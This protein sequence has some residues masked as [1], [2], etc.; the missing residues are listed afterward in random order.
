MSDSSGTSGVL[1]DVSEASGASAEVPCCAEQP[2]QTPWTMWFDRVSAGAAYSQ[3][4]HRLG[5][6]TTVQGFWRTYCN[7]A[8]PGQLQ[9]GDNYHMF[10]GALQPAMETIPGGGCWLYRLQPGAGQQLG[11]TEVNRLWES[12]LLTLVG[13]SL[14]EACVVGAGVSVRHNIVVLTTWCCADDDQASIQRVGQRLQAVFGAE[15]KLQ[16][17]A[18]QAKPSTSSG[19]SGGG[20]SSSGSSTTSRPAHATPQHIAASPAAS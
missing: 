9:P 14:G 10:R 13:E 15:A 6:I 11:D 12:L 5:T 17:R 16:W 3:S 20:G 8:R 18:M 19:G 2:L 1:R 7:L 4:L